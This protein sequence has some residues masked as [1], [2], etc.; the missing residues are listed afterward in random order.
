MA[1]STISQLLLAHRGNDPDASVITQLSLLALAGLVLRG[2]HGVLGVRNGV[3]L[4][5]IFA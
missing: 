4:Y 3:H 5:T 1:V 2:L